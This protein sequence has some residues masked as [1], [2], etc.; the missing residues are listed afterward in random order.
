MTRRA[1][2]ITSAATLM[3]RVRQVEAKPSPNG[4]LTRRTLKYR[5]RS[6]SSSAAAGVSPV[7]PDSAAVG[8]GR[9]TDRRSSASR[10]SAEA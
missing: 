3:S 6:G 10:F 4:S 9:A 2:V 5:L 8:A 7:C 1:R